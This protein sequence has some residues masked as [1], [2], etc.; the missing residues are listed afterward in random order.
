M[1]KILAT[2]PQNDFYNLKISEFSLD[3]AASELGIYFG[4][5][6]FCMFLL[7]DRIRGKKAKLE[8]WLLFRKLEVFKNDA[9][10]SERIVNYLYFAS[11]F[12][13]VLPFVILIAWTLLI[14]Y[15]KS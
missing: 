6:S 10:N 9:H 8:Y 7:L 4:L 14:L 12:Y 1:S 3:E 13:L 11:F 15:D 5:L 2:L